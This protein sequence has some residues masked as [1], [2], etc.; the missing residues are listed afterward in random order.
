[1]VM[2]MQKQKCFC[3]SINQNICIPFPLYELEPNLKRGI[4]LVR[5]I[6]FS[7]LFVQKHSFSS[8]PPHPPPPC[9]F[10]TMY[11]CEAFSR[12]LCAMRKNA[13]TWKWMKLLYVWL[14]GSGRRRLGG[15]R[16]LFYACRLVCV[17][18]VSSLVHVNR[19]SSTLE[20]QSLLLMGSKIVYFENRI[21]Y[22]LYGKHSGRLKVTQN[23]HAQTVCWFGCCNWKICWSVDNWLKT[24]RT[25]SFLY[26]QETHLK[27]H[28]SFD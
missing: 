5:K 9:Q 20:D 3:P 21:P 12:V 13:Q 15:K 25:D 4:V 14:L 23:E 11:F 18:S 16:R 1:M 8:L 2:V 28:F 22:S 26:V 6:I 27:L 24:Y 17:H 7:D 19:K 10:P